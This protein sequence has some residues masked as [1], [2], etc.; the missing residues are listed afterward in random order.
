MDAEAT[1]SVPSERHYEAHDGKGRADDS[2]GKKGAWNAQASLCAF[3]ASF[4]HGAESKLPEYMKRRF[5]RSF[6]DRMRPFATTLQSKGSY[7][8]LW[9]CKSIHLPPAQSCETKK[10]DDFPV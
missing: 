1:S 10:E 2:D 9:C 3:Y 8:K 4:L 6:I 5:R 7:A